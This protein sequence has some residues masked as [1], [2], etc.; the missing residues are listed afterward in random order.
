[1]LELHFEKK[2]LKTNLL[3]NK[4]VCVCVCVYVCICI[5]V[6]IY[7]CVYIYVYTHI[8]LSHD[9]GAIVSGIVCIILAITR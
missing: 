9:F 3:C 1:M 7:M 5:Y 6:C 4:Y 2:Y 8:P